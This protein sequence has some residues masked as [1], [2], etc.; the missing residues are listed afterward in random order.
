MY[1][2]ILRLVTIV[3]I[4]ASILLI[5]QD[6]AS[7]AMSNATTCKLSSGFSYTVAATLSGNG[8]I[9]VA[10]ADAG[11]TA[12]SYLRNKA[13]III[14]VVDPNTPTCKIIA[15]Y[16]DTESYTS[17]SALVTPPI[18]RTDKSGNVYIG[19]INGSGF[20]TIYIPANAPV[21][22]PFAGM[23]TTN[24]SGLSSNITHG[25]MAVTE[26]H[27]LVM[28]A[29]FVAGSKLFSK[30]AVLPIAAIQRGGSSSA[31]WQSFSSMP[32]YGPAYSAND[33]VEGLP[34][35]SFYLAG[36][37]EHT[38]P[39]FTGGHVILNPTTMDFI[40]AVSKK[41]G[42]VDLIPCDRN[43]LL[44]IPY[45]CFYP[46]ARVGADG[47]LY[48]SY[49]A[50]ESGT[51]TRMV[52]A[53]KYNTSQKKWMGLNGPLYPER[54]SA[55]NGKDVSGTGIAADMGGNAY[56]AGTNGLKQSLVLANYASGKW[57]DS[58]YNVT[59]TEYSKPAILFT[60]YQSGVR[61]S[62]FLVTFK[63]NGADIIWTTHTGNF[64]VALNTC[65][66]TVVIED[67]ATSINKTTASGIVYVSTDCTAKFYVAK[68]TTTASPP[69]AALTSADYKTFNLDNPAISVSGLTANA[70]S[71]VHVRMFDS[72][73]K[74]VS[75]WKSVKVTTDT[76]A[77]VGATTTL[78][79][80]YN[81][82]RFTD[83]LS[84][85]GSSYADS[86][87]VRSMV[88]RFTVTAVTDPSGLDSYKINERTFSFDQGMIG[89]N[90]S[91]ILNNSTDVSKPNNVGVTV[92]LTDGAGNIEN[93][94]LDGLVF[95]N[96]A[97]TIV[98]APTPTFTA[99]AGTYDGTVT[100][101]GGSVTDD[102]YVGSG[103]TQYWGVWVANAV[104]TAP[105]SCPLETDT[106]LRWAAVNTPTYTTFSWNLQDGLDAPAITTGN[107]YY[108]T[109][110]KFLDGAG[111]P[112]SSSIS[113]ETTV[114]VTAN[115]LFVPF[116]RAQR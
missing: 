52:Y 80:P 69:S 35:G 18:A 91:V 21:K 83:S 113:F 78:T 71:Y 101:A 93:R 15:T 86:G 17:L 55:F 57:N 38:F 82:Q 12:E 74:A 31:T 14:H 24:I 37:F 60:P 100:L 63:P 85:G 66:P 16:R 97:P 41:A 116:I 47:N 107:E 61:L 114:A 50:G 42:N 5:P 96:T 3:S 73:K 51:G 34:D 20:R 112:T 72:A 53:M 8:L 1:K 27:V 56:F 49:G 94:V 48:M 43:S 11:G 109:Y 70:T 29:T 105:G 115:T 99:S 104:C 36:S 40:G 22:T 9:Y 58:G 98:S 92:A 64:N 4:C 88:G 89:S 46:S 23:K 33:S 26:K 28:A 110:I 7:A 106:A 84:M 59:N 45:G 2:T 81:V 10:L 75:S 103:S 62:V 32:A 102:L 25:G 77:T 108:K 67:G 79:S 54:I 30:Y 65:T 90:Q 13:Q 95:D 87:Y 6:S 111:N 44:T 68:V 39:K 19:K 76:V